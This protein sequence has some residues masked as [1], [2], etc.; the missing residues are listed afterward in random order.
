MTRPTIVQPGVVLTI[1]LSWVG[2]LALAFLLGL[3]AA[4]GCLSQRPTL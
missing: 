2:L 4:G 3:R 1:F